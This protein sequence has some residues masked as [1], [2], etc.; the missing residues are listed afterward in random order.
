MAISDEDWVLLKEAKQ[1]LENPGFAAKIT[2][3]V[4]APVEKAFALLPQKLTEVVSAATQKALQVALGV[5][6]GSM[7]NHIGGRSYDSWHTL[8]VIATG[9]GGGALGLPALTVELPVSTTVMLRSIADIARSQG[10]DLTGINSRLACLEV[11]AFGGKSTRDDASETGY[12]AVRALL[13][14][15]VTDAAKYAAER[16]LA[17]EGAPPLVRLIV[18][19]ADRFGVQVSEKVAA[20]GVPV[21]GALGGALINWAFI[22]YFQDIARAHFTVRRLERKYGPEEVRKTYDQL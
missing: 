4:G 17:K 9:A 15:S 6:I 18:Q 12:F 10:E 7:H 11:F 20:Q 5:A 8:S 21:V 14:A 19:I 22:D 1:I 16:G 13:A 2:N 3:L